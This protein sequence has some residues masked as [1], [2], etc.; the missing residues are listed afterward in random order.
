[1]MVT[2]EEAK[3]LVCPLTMRDFAKGAQCG[4]LGPD[5]MAWRY[6]DHATDPTRGWCGLAGKPEWWPK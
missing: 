6:K 2:V 3:K 1:M 4:C 5:C